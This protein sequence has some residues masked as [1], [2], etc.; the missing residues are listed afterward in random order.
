[1]NIEDIISVQA[2][3][4]KVSEEFT[5]W[6]IRFKAI[7]EVTDLLDNLST[8]QPTGESSSGGMW[9]RKDRKIY[10]YKRVLYTTG[11]AGD[12]V[13]QYEESSSGKAAWNALVHKYE[14]RG[15]GGKVELLSEGVDEVADAGA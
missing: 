1:M 8:E 11:D 15:M 2:V 9:R 7:L 3:Q 12:L 14:P 5:E 10:Y 13:A 4:W 6:K